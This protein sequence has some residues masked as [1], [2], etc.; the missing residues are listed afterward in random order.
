MDNKIEL[1]VDTALKLK[2]QSSFNLMRYMGPG[3]GWH[4]V[5]V[6]EVIP[7]NGEDHEVISIEPNHV[8]LRRMEVEKDERKNL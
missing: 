8:L 2:D 6:G 5:E 7:F 1:T 3:K 4:K